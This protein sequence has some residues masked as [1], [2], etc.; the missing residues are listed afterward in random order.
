ME[1]FPNLHW[2][3]AGYAN[4]YLYVEESGLTLVDTGP[5][6]REEKILAYIGQTLKLPPDAL[7]RILITHADWDHAGSACALHETTGAPVLAGRESVDYLRRGKSPPHMPRPVQFFVD[8]LA[9]YSPLPEGALKVVADGEALP[10]CGGLEVLSTPGHTPDHHSF[11]SAE[12]GIIFAGDAL[13]T[14][15]GTLGL[16]AGFVTADVDA[17]R[18]SARRLLAL[19]PAVFA[20]GHGEPLQG[21]TLRDLMTVLQELKG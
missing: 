9:R 4:V 17:A 8:R 19:A 1:I 14:R 11:Y 5:P 13:G 20:C 12:T 2:L 10:S 6:G 18:R 3:E 16:S 7:R 21:H 15:S